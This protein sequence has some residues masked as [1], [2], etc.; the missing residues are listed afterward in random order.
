[1]GFKPSPHNVM[2]IFC[3]AYEII[4]GNPTDPDNLFCWKA[5]ELNLLGTTTYDSREPWVS[6]KRED[7]YIANDFVDYIDNIRPYGNGLDKA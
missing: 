7:G 5:V 6:K 1:M 2:G 3:W 4:R